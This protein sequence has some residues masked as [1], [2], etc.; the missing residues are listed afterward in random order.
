[1]VQRGTVRE[2][3]DSGSLID[4]VL[5]VLIFEAFE[6]GSHNIVLVVLV[7]RRTANVHEGFNAASSPAGS[8]AASRTARRLYNAT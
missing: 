8:I 4:G 5:L 3:C 6:H 7:A 1:M 2:A